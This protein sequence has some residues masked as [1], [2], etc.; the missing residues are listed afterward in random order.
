M[1]IR[2]SSCAAFSCAAFSAAAF[3]AAAFSSAL[4]SRSRSSWKARCLATCSSSNLRKR[5]AEGE[6]D[7]AF[8]SAETL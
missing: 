3:S 8:G 5:F 7:S 4:A 6:S 1:C 2:D